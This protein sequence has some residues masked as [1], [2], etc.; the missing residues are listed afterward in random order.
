MYYPLFSTFEYWYFRIYKHKTKEHYRTLIK[1]S[2]FISVK[3]FLSYK[4]F[5]VFT[6]FQYFFKTDFDMMDELKFWGTGTSHQ[7]NET[8]LIQQYLLK[9]QYLRSWQRSED[10]VNFTG[11]TLKV[12]AKVSEHPRIVYST[13]TLRRNFKDG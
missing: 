3:T 12:M 11:I 1:F 9:M 4:H 7:I 13:Y 5:S 2:E 8:L 10:D 6:S